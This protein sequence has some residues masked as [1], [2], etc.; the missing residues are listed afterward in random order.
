VEGE[1]SFCVVYSIAALIGSNKNE[2]ETRN[3][4]VTLKEKMGKNIWTATLYKLTCNK[5][6]CKGK[7]QAY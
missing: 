1:K 5:R 2:N 6:A 3:T 4:R 7:I